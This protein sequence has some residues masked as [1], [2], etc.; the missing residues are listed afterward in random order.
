MG[1]TQGDVLKNEES[2][3]FKMVGSCEERHKFG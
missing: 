2:E 1:R 3:N